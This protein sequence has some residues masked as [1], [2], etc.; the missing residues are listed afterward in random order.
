MAI[1]AFAEFEERG[2]RASRI[3]ASARYPSKQI[4]NVFFDSDDVPNL[5]YADEM[6]VRLKCLHSVVAFRPSHILLS[7]DILGGKPLYYGSDLS[8]SSFKSYIDGE[9]HEVLPGEVIKL[10]YTGKILERK[11]YAFEEVFKI[12]NADVEELIEIIE[13]TLYKLKLKV[14][15]I[16]FSGGLDSSLLAAIYD[17]PLISVTASGKEE[18]WLRRAAKMIG[19]EIEVLRV[20]KKEVLEA[21][22]AVKKIIETDDFLQISIAVP[23]HLAMQFAKSLGYSEIVFGQGAD[24]LFGG[25]RRYVDMDPCELKDALMNDLRNIG[26]ANLIRDNKLAYKNEIKLTTPY[27]DWDIIDAAVKLPPEYKVRREGGRV[28]RK[29]VLRKIAEKYLP[30]EIAWREKKAIQYSTGIAKILKRYM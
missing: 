20:D 5:R 14:G 25:Y 9:A 7:R 15:C 4:G 13:R 2:S 21:V 17:L 29:Y 12:G 18:E 8:I 10:D 28:I 30:G 16:A 23:I 11:K 24:E 19:R 27:L 3:Y 6:P 22:D 1:Y 26:D